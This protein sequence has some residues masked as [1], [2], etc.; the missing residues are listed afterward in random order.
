MCEMLVR[1]FGKLIDIS[2]AGRKPGVGGGTPNRK[3]KFKDHPGE[4]K[5]AERKSSI[6]SYLLEY[7]IKHSG[8]PEGE[9]GG[10]LAGC[11][12]REGESQTLQSMVWKGESEGRGHGEARERDS[13]KIA[14]Q[15][16]SCEEGGDRPEVFGGVVRRRGGEKTLGGHREGESVETEG[17]KEGINLGRRG[18]GKEVRGYIRGGKAVLTNGAEIGSSSILEGEQKRGRSEGG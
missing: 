2:D 15:A 4:K 14:T 7:G 18:A 3:K 17:E 8:I 13:S 12:G 9:R 5:I 11:W 10:N 1:G 6:C 16:V